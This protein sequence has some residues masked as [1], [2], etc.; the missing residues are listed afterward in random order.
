MEQSGEML[1]NESMQ[2]M[3]MTVTG[4]TVAATAKHRFKFIVHSTLN[5]HQTVWFLV[6]YKSTPAKQY[7][8]FA[9]PFLWMNMKKKGLNERHYSNYAVLVER[10]HVSK[11][12]MMMMMEQIRR[13]L[14]A[15]NRWRKGQI[16]SYRS[17]KHL[18][19]VLIQPEH[20][21]VSFQSIWCT[22][23]YCAV[24]AGAALFSQ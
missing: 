5:Y 9:Q 11:M 6:L 17:Q 8:I 15:N 22:I 16:I 10:I 1:K 20:V 3:R 14:M 18:F 24:F 4:T 12:M 7:K 19:T 2:K 21:C 13:K 23:K